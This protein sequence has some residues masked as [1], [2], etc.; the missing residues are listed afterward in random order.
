MTT[1]AKAWLFQYD[2]TRYEIEEFMIKRGEYDDWHVTRHLDEIRVGDRV[3]FRRS[4][5]GPLPR[6]ISAVGRVLSPVYTR[7]PPDGHHYADVHYELQVEPTLTVDEVRGDPILGK[8]GAL[9]PGS[10]GTTFA[11][12]SQQEARL[13]A[14]AA[15]RLQPYPPHR[16]DIDPSL[17]LDERTRALIPVVQR[18]GQPEFRNQLIQAYGGRCA[19][20]DCDAIDALEAAHISPYLGPKT[21]HVSNGLL[22]RAD[23]HTLFDRSLLSIDDERMTVIIHVDLKSTTYRNLD[24]TAIHLP[25]NPAQRPDIAAVRHH[26]KLSGL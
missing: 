17:Q 24:G 4:V 12:D 19:I 16:Q 23:I 25:T 20:T 22:L 7:N 10:Q 3:Y 15:D 14:L 2:Q 18:Q 21:N 8:M 1:V 26:R 9:V 6:G 13:E 5:A 11:L